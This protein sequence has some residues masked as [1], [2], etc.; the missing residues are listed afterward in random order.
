MFAGTKL[1]GKAL[2][3]RYSRPRE[4]EGTHKAGNGWRNRG[5][6]LRG[7]SMCNYIA[8]QD[9]LDMIAEADWG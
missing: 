7:T 6:C 8:E 9:A 4:R 1:I 3:E 5:L 2:E